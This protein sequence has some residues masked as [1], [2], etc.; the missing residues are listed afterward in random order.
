MI[1]S[2]ILSVLVGHSI[3]FDSSLLLHE[4]AH[5]QWQLELGADSPV[6]KGHV[7]NAGTTQSALCHMCL[8]KH[9]VISVLEQASRFCSSI[10]R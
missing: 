10:W 3:I 8:R 6:D 9:R 4:L 5:V 7:N 1:F 2:Q